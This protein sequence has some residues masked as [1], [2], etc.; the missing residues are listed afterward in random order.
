MPFNDVDENDLHVILWEKK[1]K[2]LF[3]YDKFGFDVV[4]RKVTETGRGC[5]LGWLS[6]SGTKGHNFEVYEQNNKRFIILDNVYQI[7]RL[8]YYDK[9][10]L[11]F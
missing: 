5:D 1:K 6:D 3:G 10:E 11:S 9:P 7:L 2:K 8:D 4:I